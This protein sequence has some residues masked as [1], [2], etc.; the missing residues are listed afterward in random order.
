[1][2]CVASLISCAYWYNSQSSIRCLV[3]LAGVIVIISQF[4]LPSMFDSISSASIFPEGPQSYQTAQLDYSDVYTR[5][6]EEMAWPKV[7]KNSR[8][9]SE[10]LDMIFYTITK[11]MHAF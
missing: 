7:H 11:S 1:M 3:S 2:T 6:K 9:G 10:R 5:M 8:S 4:I